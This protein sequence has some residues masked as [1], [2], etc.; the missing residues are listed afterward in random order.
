MPPHL[1]MHNNQGYHS[2]DARPENPTKKCERLGRED[3]A[4][5]AT[6]FMDAEIF[7][8]LIA[9][10]CWELEGEIYQSLAK[11]W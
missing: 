5:C 11:V 10:A 8:V 7:R 6:S 1:K 2:L 3:A 9:I 4:P